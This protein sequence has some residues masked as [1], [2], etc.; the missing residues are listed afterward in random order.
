MK[1]K[2]AVTGMAALACMTT[3]AH[4]QSAGSFVL[5]TGWFHLAPQSSSE[6]LRVTS[7]GGSP[8]NITEANTGASLSSADTIGFTLGYFVTDHIAAEFVLG[9]PPSFDLTGTGSFERF[10]KLGQAKQWSPTLLFK[11]FFNAPTAAFRPYLGIGVSRVWF[12]DAKITNSAFEAN[13]LHGP[14][15]V[16]TDSSWAPVFNAGFTY[17]F[18]QH[19][20]AGVSISYLPLSTTAKLNTAARTPVGTLNVQS[21]TK[22]KLNPIVSYVNIGYRF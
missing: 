21:Q 17:A 18:D 3:A 7:I 9:Y 12:T 22:I 14:T 15:S 11:Y 5:S 6:P 8:T 16:D 20:F 2:Q 4:A 19:W 10:G 13:V 1:L